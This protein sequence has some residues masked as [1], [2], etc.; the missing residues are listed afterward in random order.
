MSRPQKH[1]CIESAVLNE[2]KGD[3]QALKGDKKSLTAHRESLKG[4]K[5]AFRHR[6]KVLTLKPPYY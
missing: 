3:E 5:K 4:E 1:V 6:Q 2:L